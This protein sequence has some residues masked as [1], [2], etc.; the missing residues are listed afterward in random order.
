MNGIVFTGKSNGRTT[1]LETY[2]MPKS[3]T[4]RYVTITVNG[5]TVNAWASITEVQ[6]DGT[7]SP[8]PPSPPS[9]TPTPPSPP[10]PSPTIDVN[11]V[12]MLYPSA[13]NGPTYFYKM[14]DNIQSSK[15]INTDRNT[16]TQMTEG[17]L[18]FKRLTANLVT[19]SDGT[20]DGK[21]CR[22]NVN[23][24]G[25]ISIQ[26]HTWKDPNV[27]YIWSATDSKN[28][29]FTYYFRAVNKVGDH[30][31]ASTKWRSNTS[32]NNK[33]PKAAS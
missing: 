22:V 5:N 30:T 28:A 13:T 7:T 21:T 20:P 4:G 14:T 29:E 8:L 32:P 1:N 31:T 18:T 15:Y 10:S 9:P 26:A 11:G 33:S 12:T 17:N 27:Q 23:A 6:I 3:T 19:Y 25:F 2:I 16:A 24:G